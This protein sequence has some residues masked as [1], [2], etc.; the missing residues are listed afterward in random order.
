MIPS[1]GRLGLPYPELG[2]PANGADLGEKIKIA[3]LHRLILWCLV[4]ICLFDGW[5]RNMR[6]RGDDWL[7]DF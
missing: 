2:K 5:I 6:F 3:I 1:K 7:G 4:G